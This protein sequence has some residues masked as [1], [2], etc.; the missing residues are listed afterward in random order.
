MSGVSMGGFPHQG[1]C[2]TLEALHYQWEEHR[3]CGKTR[4]GFKSWLLA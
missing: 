1:L 2:V 4:R 3:L